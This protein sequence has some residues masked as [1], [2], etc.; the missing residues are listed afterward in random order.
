MHRSD[1]IFHRLLLLK[2]MIGGRFPVKLLFTTLKK[3]KKNI[4]KNTLHIKPI[5]TFL[6]SLR[7]NNLKKKHG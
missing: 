5:G 3:K 4:N 1:N 7:I 6:A 2:P